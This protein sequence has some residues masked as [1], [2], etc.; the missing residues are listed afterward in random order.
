MR[1]GIQPKN[2]NK[3]IAGTGRLVGVC[4][5]WTAIGSNNHRWNPNIFWVCHYENALCQVMVKKNVAA[6]PSQKI[7]TNSN[8]I[9]FLARHDFLDSIID[10][11]L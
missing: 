6:A 11:E 3:Q 7:Q 9:T 1:V 8:Y 2:E 4:F 5:L 10:G